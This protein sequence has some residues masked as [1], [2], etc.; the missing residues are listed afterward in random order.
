GDATSGPDISEEEHVVTLTEER[1]VV[2]QETVPLE[3]GP[4]DK[5]TVTQQQQVN[6][7][8]RKE[9]IELEGDSTTGT[10]DGGRV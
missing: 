5:D 9:E 1:V 2:D 7:Q 8:V 4:R 10:T 6:E 3:R